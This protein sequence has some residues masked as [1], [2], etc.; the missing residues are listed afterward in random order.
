LKGKSKSIILK[1]EAEHRIRR[2]KTKNTSAEISSTTG[3]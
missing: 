3:L 1:T 2:L